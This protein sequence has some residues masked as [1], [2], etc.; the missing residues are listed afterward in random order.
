MKYRLHYST[1]ECVNLCDG[2]SFH[3]SA[4]HLIKSRDNFD[5]YFGVKSVDCD[6]PRVNTDESCFH[7]YCEHA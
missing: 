6:G 4:Y 3:I 1:K 7:V 5:G 2:K